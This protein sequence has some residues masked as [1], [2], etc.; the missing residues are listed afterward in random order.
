MKD[1]LYRLSNCFKLT[2]SAVFILLLSMSAFAFQNTGDIA[3]SVRT[4]SGEAISSAEVTLFAKGCR[5]KTECPREPCKR[6]CTPQRSVT[7]ND[8][9]SFR[10]ANIPIGNY[11]VGVEASGFEAFVAEVSVELFQTSTVDVVLEQAPINN[12]ITVI[13]NKCGFACRIKRFFKKIF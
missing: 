4:Q 11:S 13:P 7:V 12:E 5:C 2:F 8:I 1:Y 6:C 9:G 3:G 10:I